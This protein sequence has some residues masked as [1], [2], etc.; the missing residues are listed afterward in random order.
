M[1]EK[2]FALMGS[3][4]HPLSLMGHGVGEGTSFAVEDVGVGGE[5]R[6]CL[7]STFCGGCLEHQECTNVLG[8]LFDT[9]NIA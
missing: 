6:D 1:K 4:T 8:K 9:L 2:Q 3:C 7:K 5:G